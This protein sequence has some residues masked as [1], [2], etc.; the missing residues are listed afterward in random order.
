MFRR[1]TAATAC[2]AAMLLTPMTTMAPANA[3][4]NCQARDKIIGVLADR[5]KETRRGFGLQDDMR[6]L[7][8]FAAESGSWTAIVS[9]PDGRSCIVAI[10]EAWTDQEPEPQG[11][12]V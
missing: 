12:D 3:A 8:I 6:I 4:A 11:P 10:G 5:Y 7:E 1:I 9:F 2:A